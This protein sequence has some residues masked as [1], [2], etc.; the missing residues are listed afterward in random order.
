MASLFQ[1]ALEQEN[2]EP[3]G[4]IGMDLDGTLAYYDE[5]RGVEHIG[6]PI[7]EMVSLVT[8]YLAEGI[9]VKIFTARAAIEDKEERELAI[10]TIQEW[11][12]KHIGIGLDVTAIKSPM[13]IKFYDD[14]AIQV[15]E[16]TGIIVE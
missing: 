8:K 1:M 14:R 16:N 15:K 7:P 5:W 6:N 4:F 3:E 12:L 11:C 13:M 10:K 9:E 2:I